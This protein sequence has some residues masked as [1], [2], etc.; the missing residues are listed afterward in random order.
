MVV[1]SEFSGLF[2]VVVFS[3]SS[4][5]WVAH[6]EHKNMGGVLGGHNHYQQ[7]LTGGKERE[8]GGVGGEGH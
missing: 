5:S 7:A 6:S 4:N 1:V 8:G 2:L 3:S